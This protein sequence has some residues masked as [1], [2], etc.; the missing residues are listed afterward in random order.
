MLLNAVCLLLAFLFSASVIAKERNPDMSIGLVAVG[1]LDQKVLEALKRDLN[2]VF[3]KQVVLGKEMEEPE[4]A[5]N[6]KKNQYLST[7][8]L[9]TLT[10]Q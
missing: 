6:K 1:K 5:F 9:K 3:G 2:K 10:E 7:A 8:I 4:Y